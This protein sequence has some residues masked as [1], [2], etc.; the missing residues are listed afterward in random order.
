M[1]Q[2]EAQTFR[3]R[4]ERRSKLLSAAL[5]IAG[6]TIL[7]CCLI[8][9]CRDSLTMLLISVAALALW[10]AVFCITA[11]RL[12]RTRLQLDQRDDPAIRTG[13]F[14]AL[15]AE[16]E[17]DQF[18][19]LTDA[20]VLFAESHGSVIEL[21]LRRDNRTYYITIDPEAVF[22]ATDEEGPNASETELPLADFR[23]T[24][25]VF[26]TLRALIDHP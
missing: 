12:N 5:A 3:R 10:F 4:F 13:L 20:K 21:E 17:Q 18:K 6:I 9:A 1:N 11:S 26:S 23:N 2:T 25:H 15:M 24:A 7:A 16:F 14:G 8:A 19:D 22:L